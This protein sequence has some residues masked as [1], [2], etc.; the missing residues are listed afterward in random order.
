MFQCKDCR[1]T[2]NE[3]V[4]SPFNFIEVPTDILFQ[5]S[6][7]LMQYKLIVTI[8]IMMEWEN[9]ISVGDHRVIDWS[10]RLLSFQSP[11]KCRLHQ[12]IENL[13]LKRQIDHFQPIV[14]A[15]VYFQPICVAYQLVLFGL[16]Q[17]RQYFCQ[18]SCRSLVPL[19][20]Q[21][22]EQAT[23]GYRLSLLHLHC[24]RRETALQTA[25]NETLVG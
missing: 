15:S 6:L 19:L 11:F 22:T 18:L 21:I 3:H 10:K 7:C 9:R 20:Q 17:D 8:S 25:R 5:V 14:S 4:D 24:Q 13:F 2:H 12:F 16:L 1:R 23:L